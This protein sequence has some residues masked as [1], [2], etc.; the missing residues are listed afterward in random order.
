MASSYTDNPTGTVRPAR[1]P[2]RAVFQKH[3]NSPQTPQRPPTDPRIGKILQNP[4]LDFHQV[5]KKAAGM[6]RPLF[7]L[8]A[9]FPEGAPGCDP[10][11][12]R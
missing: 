5:G 10:R 7:P 4:V 8:A 1:H 11:R 3:V 9:L 12:G 2:G 6:Y